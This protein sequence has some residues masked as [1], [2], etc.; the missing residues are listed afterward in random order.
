MLVK[1]IHIKTNQSRKTRSL[2]LILI[3]LFLTSHLSSL[4]SEAA[5]S[6]DENY[7]IEVEDL[8][9]TLPEPTSP[10][11]IIQKELKSISTP[12]DIPPPYTI[13]AT[14]DSFSFLLSQTAI[15]F[16]ALSAT[17]PVVR[18]SDITFSTPFYGAQV[19]GYANHPLMNTEKVILP[20]TTCDTGTCSQ[21]IASNWENNLT[22]GF[23]FR[24]ESAS[25]EVCGREFSGTNSFKQFAD[26]SAKESLR[27]I[28]LNH[29]SK[30][31]TT[32]KIGYKVNI[33]GTQTVGGYSNTVTYI[34]VPNF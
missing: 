2:A 14:N 4:T 6:S 27:T 3:S 11:R 9:T 1:N 21:T 25:S 29:Q 33:S 34:A 26:L 10:P 22:Y 12:S 28:G 20:D 7:S 5:V 24:C 15:D 17:N 8:N 19:V 16:G 23:G 13:T 32:L 31:S 18:T 30:A